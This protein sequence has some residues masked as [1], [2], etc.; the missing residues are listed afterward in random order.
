MDITERYIRAKD[1]QRRMAA[2]KAKAVFRKTSEMIA[3]ES[4]SA[5]LEG[6]AYFSFVTSRGVG[7]RET[8]KPAF[9]YG[10]FISECQKINMK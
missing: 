2:S 9:N 3:V 5:M 10:V 8:E 7:Y 1:M 6:R 4:R